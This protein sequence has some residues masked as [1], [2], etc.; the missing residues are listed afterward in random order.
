MFAYDQQPAPGLSSD[1]RNK[2]SQFPIANQ[3]DVRGWTNGHLLEDV[4]CR[5]HRLDEDRGFVGQ[6]T[7]YFDQI[8]NRERK[9]L[10][11]RAIAILDAKHGAIGTM[12]AISRA[13]PIALL[14]PRVNLADNTTAYE[15]G[16]GRL[17]NAAYELVTQRA[18]KAGVAFDYFEVSAADPR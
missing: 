10:S 17:G 1:K 8:P 5:S 18:M 14:A 15:R 6:L 12:P 16:I 13:A 11:E 4:Q 7:R 9:K 3:R 2:L